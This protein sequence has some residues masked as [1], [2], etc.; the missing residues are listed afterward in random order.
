MHDIMGEIKLYS[1]PSWSSQYLTQS[2]IYT[3]LIH[4]I[5]LWIR[6]RF[7]SLLMKFTSYPN[8]LNW[9]VIKLRCV[10]SFPLTICALNCFGKY[11][12][13]M[14]VVEISFHGRGLYLNY[15]ANS[16]VADGLAMQGARASASMVLIYFIRNISASAS[17]EINV[18]PVTCNKILWLNA[19]VIIYLYNRRNDLEFSCHADIY[20]L[21]QIIIYRQVL[22]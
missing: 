15:P 6:F 5:T 12:N 18:I 16:V 17:K 11:T 19:M 1:D 9:Q 8:Y 4:D 14:V 3:D 7:Y 21:L 10:I 13:T 20:I 22:K 2:N